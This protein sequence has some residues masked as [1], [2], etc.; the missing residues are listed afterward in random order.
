MSIWNDC[1]N[2]DSMP[3]YGFPLQIEVKDNKLL[4]NFPNKYDPNGNQIQKVA[5]K[6]SYL[7]GEIEEIAETYFIIKIE[8][9]KLAKFI[10]YSQFEFEYNP[11]Y[12]FKVSIRSWEF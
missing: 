12:E 6:M 5:D 4:F 11:D 9:S 3:F 8:S 1:I 2:T 10:Y 7:L